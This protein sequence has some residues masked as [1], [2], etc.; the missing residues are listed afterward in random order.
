MPNTGNSSVDAGKPIK[1]LDQKVLT[2]LAS[3]KGAL[4]LAS[5][6]AGVSA[7]SVAGPMAREM[8][9][10]EVGDYDD[11]GR[12]NFVTAAKNS[13]A[14]Y[15][16]IV[17]TGTRLTE[18]DYT[19]NLQYVR[20]N[21]I[22]NAQSAGWAG[23]YARLQNPVLNDLGVAKIQ[24]GTAMEAVSYYKN[25]PNSFNGVDALDL[26]KYV[27]NTQQLAADLINPATTMRVSINLEAVV[28][29]QADLW[30]SQRIAG[31]Q[32]L[33]DAD[34]AAFTA[35]YSTIGER[36]LNASYMSYVNQ[37]GDPGLYRPDLKQMSA[38]E[39]LTWA[40]INSEP[41][42]AVTLQN[43][44]SAATTTGPA[45]FIDASVYPTDFQTIGATNVPGVTGATQAFDLAT[46]QKILDFFSAIKHQLLQN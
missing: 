3:F 38:A 7:L 10:V 45:G 31:W 30:A 37:G 16:S 15:G 43:A 29:R 42:N 35:G 25:N 8:N 17:L 32:Q 34:K 2:D 11:Y 41:S 18:Q 23:D 5:S 4:D 9:K 22:S 44:L 14:L 33:S 46:G 36:T 12:S 19:T 28:A 20:D 27:N 13:V 1:P 40:A 26:L 24:L 39:Y 6:A 21:N